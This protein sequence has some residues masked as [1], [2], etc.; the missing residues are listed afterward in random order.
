[1][2]KTYLSPE[3][4]TQALLATLRKS[5]PPL[6][7]KYVVLLCA[8]RESFISAGELFFK[9][10]SNAVIRKSRIRETLHLSTDADSSTDTKT[11]RNGNFFL[12]GEVPIFFCQ[13]K[14]PNFLFYFFLEGGGSPFF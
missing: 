2:K 14:G 12:G 8:T 1:M 7:S 6:I 13:G 3:N 4:C 9:L 11:D 10:H 5:V